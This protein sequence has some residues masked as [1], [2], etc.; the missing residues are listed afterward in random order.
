LLWYYSL[1]TEDGKAMT[2]N[3]LSLKKID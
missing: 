1:F 3:D 2:A